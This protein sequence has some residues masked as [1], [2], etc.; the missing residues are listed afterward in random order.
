MTTTELTPEAVHDAMNERQDEWLDLVTDLISIPSENPPGDTT[1]IADYF[2]SFLQDRNVPYEVI[3]PNEEMPNVVAHFEGNRGDPEQGRHLTFNGHLDTFPRRNEDLWDRSPFSGEVDDGKIHGRGTS[4][5]YGG[6]TASI[7]SFLYLFEHRDSIEGKVSLAAVSDEE[8][9]ARWGTKH[10]VKNYPEYNG[11]AVI[12]GEPSSNGIIRFAERGRA[13]IQITV[14]GE[15]AHTCSVP[16]GVSAIDVLTDILVDLR[17]LVADN[18]IVDVPAD[19]REVILSAKEDMDVAYGE[20]ATDR[21]LKL[22]VNPGTIKGGEK[23][24][25]SAENASAE[26]DIRLPIGTSTDEAVTAVETIADRYPA[27]IEVN[28][29]P[30]VTNAFKEPTASPTDH[31]IFQHLQMSAA[32]A[33]QGQA[34]SFSCALAGTDCAYYRKAGIPAAVYGPSP[35]NLGSQNEYIYV[36]DF[37][38]VVRAQAAASTR[39]MLRTDEKGD[40]K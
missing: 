9:G 38:E 20:G 23:I 13:W 26:V 33:R 32:E 4:D 37:M 27:K 34:P 1:E 6:F 3:A 39:F 12:S 40:T 14:T 24:N 18:D 36:E 21:I 28:P 31:P 11:D 7:A 5:M 25:L 29:A 8:S 19:K 30:S 17:E 35:H 16:R 10:L 22:R 2:T 15:S